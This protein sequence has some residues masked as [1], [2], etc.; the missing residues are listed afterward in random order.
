MKIQAVLFA[1]DY[2]SLFCFFL[3]QS[4]K[5]LRIFSLG[6]E[7]V[8]LCERSGWITH[9]CNDGTEAMPYLNST[10]WPTMNNKLITT[11]L[12][13]VEVEVSVLTEEEDSE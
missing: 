7:G 11:H 6:L 10:L 9:S 4:N 5:V 1:L 3:P 13:Q 8:S 2:S 12:F